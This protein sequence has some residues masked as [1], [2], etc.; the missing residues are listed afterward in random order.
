M[1]R[2]RRQ[3]SSAWRPIEEQCSWLGVICDL[4]IV[5]RLLQQPDGGIAQTLCWSPQYANS[6]TPCTLIRK[7][8]NPQESESFSI[9]SDK[10]LLRVRHEAVHKVPVILNP[11]SHKPGET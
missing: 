6:P 8:E 9:N 11:I 3:N 5:R 1:R 7:V 4:K 2:T 10:W